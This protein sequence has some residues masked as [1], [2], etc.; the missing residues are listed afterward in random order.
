MIKNKK[1]VISL[2]LLFTIIITM[3]LANSQIASAKETIYVSVSSASKTVGDEVIVT[4]NLSCSDAIMGGELWLDYNADI[5]QPLEGYYFIS[6]TSI[7]FTVA[8]ETSLSIK[9]KAISAGTAEI[10]VDTNRTILAAA[11][12]AMGSEPR[13]T[14][15]SSPGHVTVSAPVNYSSDNNLKSL[16]ISPGVLSPAFSPNVT[17]YTT[18]VGADCD[19]LV[20]SAIPSDQKASVSISGAKLDPGANVTTVT[21]KAE[22]GATKVYTIRTTKDAAGPGGQD[23]QNPGEP[24]QPGANGGNPQSVQVDG[25]D[26]TVSSDFEAHPLPV[27]YVAIDYDYHGTA[28]KAGQGVNTRLILMYLEN[29]DG[30]GVSGFYIYDSVSR[31]F[32]LY[33]ELGQPNITYVILPITDQMEKPEGF[34][35]AECTI[36]DRKVTVLM[37]SKGEYCLFYGISSN[38]V[39]GW[40]CYDLKDK[41]V[42]TYFPGA[43]ENRIQA[44]STE[45]VSDHTSAENSRIWKI[46]ALVMT[47]IA[48]VAAGAA[49]L[50]AGK[51]A[52]N[53][54]ALLDAIKLDSSLGNADLSDGED[55][56]REEDEESDEL[57]FRVEEPS[58]EELQEGAADGKT[59]TLPA[60]EQE[61]LDVSSEESQEYEIL[62]VEDL[63]DKK[64]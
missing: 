60:A 64:E 57:V 58:A 5:L 22:N 25:A 16:S 18:S 24:Q 51:A 29:T 28:V 30:K 63:E 61:P 38:G 56:L 31:T 6:G 9:F 59:T 19:R 62:D 1:K 14:V 8:G 45:A 21:V 33:H 43:F 26:Y 27:G 52:K 48:L 23:P 4:V 36:N 44:G 32:T 39:T 37:S 49:A 2:A 20:V 41:T 7:K 40:F 42:Q 3:F 13:S 46:V 11:N 12:D 47:L 15:V 50:L 55:I 34:T 53:R 35:K 54:R 17:E 10:S